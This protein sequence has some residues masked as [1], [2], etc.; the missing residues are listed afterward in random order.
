MHE[1][2]IAYV[3]YRKK[4]DVVMSRTLAKCSIGVGSFGEPET[5]V[6]LSPSRTIRISFWS[7]VS[8]MSGKP[9]VERVL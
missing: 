1:E 5:G 7:S 4:Q 2:Y 8:A 6:E 9:S 3:M